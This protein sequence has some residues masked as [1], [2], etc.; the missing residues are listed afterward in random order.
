MTKKSRLSAADPLVDLVSA[1]GTAAREHGWDAVS[2]AVTDTLTAAREGR[3]APA[4]AELGG[5]F[6]AVAA[7]GR[8]SWTPIIAPLVT[9]LVAGVKQPVADKR[10]WADDPLGRSLEIPI[11]EHPVGP[12][13]RAR[14]RRLLAV[15]GSAQIAGLAAV[16]TKAPPAKQAFGVGMMAPGGGFLYTRDPALFA[17]SLVAFAFSLLLWFG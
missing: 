6:A 5:V 17:A 13:S 7:V 10:G 1:A 14:Q 9:A 2:R 8:S 16:V 12:L 4:P 3:P 11:A 15:L